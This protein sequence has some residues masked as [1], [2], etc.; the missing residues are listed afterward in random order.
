M[1]KQSEFHHDSKGNPDSFDDFKKRLNYL[2][3]DLGCT[4]KASPLSN[5]KVERFYATYQKKVFG[6]IVELYENGS[7]SLYFESQTLV[8]P[9]DVNKVRKALGIN[10]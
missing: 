7:Y 2:G 10:L 1:H 4:W 3:I 6:M 9:N 8:I 5:F